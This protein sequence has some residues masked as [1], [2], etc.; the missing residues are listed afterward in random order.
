[1]LPLL[2]D[3]NF[4]YEIVR[5]LRRRL[6]G[7]NLLTVRE[8]ELLGIADPEL[9]EWAAQQGRILLTHD[10]KTMTKF[11]Y[12]R[13]N[14]GAPMPGVFVLAATLPISIAIEEIVLHYECSEPHEWLDTVHYLP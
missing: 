12:D 9:L 4:N 2:A 14:A 8:A 7:L 10:V 11:A 13:I 5:G 6:P 1:M 3:E